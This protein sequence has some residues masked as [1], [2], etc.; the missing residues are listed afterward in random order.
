MKCNK[1]FLILI[2][3]IVIL[4]LKSSDRY[5]LPDYWPTNEWKTSTPEAQGMDSGMLVHA[6][7]KIDEQKLELH[8]LL[9]I[10]NNYLVTEVYYYPYNKDIRHD[11]QS[12]GKSFTSTLVGIAVDKGF[13]KN[14][15]Q[16]VLDFFPNEVFENMDKYKE[17][18]TIEDLLT[19]RS[20]LDWPN[21]YWFSTTPKFYLNLYH[22][23]DW[24]KYILDR[25]VSFTGGGFNYSFA[26][27]HLLAEILA[28]ATKEDV[29]EYAKRHLFNPLGIKELFWPKNPQGI[30]IG[31]GGVNITPRDMAKLGCLFLYNGVW[32]DNQI[33]SREWVQKAT[34]KRDI[35]GYG[36][37]W[38]I[39]QEGIYAA[40]GYGGQC[41]YVVPQKN[42]VIVTTGSL[43]DNTDAKFMFEIITDDI[44]PSVLSDKALPPDHKN[45]EMLQR[46]IQNKACAE[47]KESVIPEFFNSYIAKTFVFEDN[48]LNLKSMWFSTIT[49]NEL[50]TVMSF[51]SEVLDRDVSYHYTIGLDNLYRS[52]EQQAY[53]YFDYYEDNKVYALL[54]GRFNDDNSL[55]I[56]E[57]HLGRPYTSHKTITIKGDKIQMDY[58]ERSGRIDKFTITGELKG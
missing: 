15:K 23:D 40:L 48:A 36:Y 29:F 31:A 30:P 49:D 28:K 4:F 47:K 34:K 41:I 21:V 51:Y 25:R 38:W 26:D 6:L 46:I 44:I 19:M 32:D 13:I 57:H 3:L 45:Y 1:I 35:Y 42:I 9:I 16:K 7:Q 10:R 52:N 37:Q 22:S 20:G 2:C 56:S 43:S 33:V 8:S 53:T 18:I 11:T 24:A 58:L 39:L 55:S 27:S 54:K 5:G 50:E 17:R 12:A 14:E